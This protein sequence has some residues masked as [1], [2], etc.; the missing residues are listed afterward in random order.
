[1]KTNRILKFT[2]SFLVVLALGFCLGSVAFYY[3]QPKSDLMP[4]AAPSGSHVLTT[5]DFSYQFNTIAYQ[6]SIIPDSSRR[7]LRMTPFVF[8]VSKARDAVVSVSVTQVRYY[9]Y[10]IDPFFEMFFPELGRQKLVPYSI[11]SMGSG[12]IINHDGYILTNAHVVKDAEE[13]FINLPDGRQFPGKLIGLDNSSDIAVLKIEGDDL[14]IASMGDSDDIMIGEYAIAIGNPFGYIL[15]ET[16]PTVTCGWISAVN[17][18]IK[19]DN[20]GK[21][22][23][24]MIQTNADIN[25]GNSGGPLINILGEVI[26]VNTFILTQGNS[27]F[28]GL[29]FALPINKARKVMNEIIKYGRVR[30][31]WTG[32]RIQDVS[33]MI[34]EHFRLK[35]ISGAVI[36]EVE[37]RSP[38][39]EAGLMNKDIIMGINS[40]KMKNSEDIMDEFSDAQVGDIFTIQIIRNGKPAEVKLKL[41]ENPQTKKSYY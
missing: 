41:K 33:P 39:D 40:K 7:R 38:G 14:P 37:S 21:M 3:L 28:I 16:G 1:M 36:L 27:G 29:G 5:S 22:Y 9:R 31:F 2:Y 11:S 15:S 17:R 18:N 23:K 34:A 19:F 8:A 24:K 13:I 26:G 20:E 6:D 30:N 32:I 35:E 12:F 10:A 25:Q 4:V